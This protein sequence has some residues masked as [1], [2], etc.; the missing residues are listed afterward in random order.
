MGQ[1]NFTGVFQLDNGNWGFRY[2]LVVDGKRREKRKVRDELGQPFKTAKQ[3]EKARTA[4]I[5]KDKITNSLP[6]STTIKKRTLKEV[7][8]E[9][10]E[11]GR[12]GKAYATIRKQDSLWK[13]HLCARFG[14][15]YIDEISSAE[16]NDYLE[17]LYYIE[18]RAFSY[19]EA[20]LKMFYLIFGQAYS[21]NYLEV[22]SYNK[23]C[24]NK[25]TKIHMPK[26]KNDEE[27]DIQFFD[28][29]EMQILDGYFKGSHAECAYM[30]GKYCGLRI[31]ECYGL[32]WENIDLQK[33]TIS[34]EQQMQY[35]NGIIKLVPLKTRNAK[36]TIYLGQKI[37]DY[38]S[39]LYQ[40]YQQDSQALKEQREQNQIFV[41]DTDGRSISSLE[42]VNTL[43]NG[44]IQTI[45]SMKY[46]AKILKKEYH[47]NF[48]YHYLRHTYGTRLAEMNTPTHLLCN[49]MGHASIAV[50]QKYYLAISKD[51]IRE[52]TNN[53]N[54]L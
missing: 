54:N 44:K 41:K 13:N 46:H 11:K 9:Y 40:Q 31:G 4:A 18:G 27:Q 35:Q 43:P 48:K 32:K 1:S 24:I 15:R 38:L 12:S 52:L 53:V 39:K 42:L 7:Y 30:L 23:M 19:V 14:G 45:N 36:R 20:F 8:E 21:R 33:G 16:I 6:P 26:L 5:L 28:R 22:G 25:D 49:Q 2:V 51:G 10:C 50:T 47:L 29:E 37:K 17:E 3:A 34:V